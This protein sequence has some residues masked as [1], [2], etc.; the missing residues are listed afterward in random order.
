MTTVWRSSTPTTASQQHTGSNSGNYA[1]LALDSIAEV[2]VQTSNFRRSM[3]APPAPRLGGH[4][5]HQ[6][7]SG[8]A[9]Y[10]RRNEDYNANT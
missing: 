7:V 2:K 9:A 1:A 4:Q 5:R 6:P 8:T 10:F 3:A